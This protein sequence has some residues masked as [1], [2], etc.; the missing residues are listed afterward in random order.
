MTIFSF[1]LI[2]ISCGGIDVP[3]EQSESEGSTVAIH[4]GFNMCGLRLLNDASTLCCTGNLW[5]NYAR[6]LKNE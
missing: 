1:S 3:R 5:K 4:F 6:T 2:E